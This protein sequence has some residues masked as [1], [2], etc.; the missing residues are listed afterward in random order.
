MAQSEMETE[1]TE[2]IASFLCLMAVFAIAMAAL[3]FFANSFS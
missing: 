1:E 2:S 3:V